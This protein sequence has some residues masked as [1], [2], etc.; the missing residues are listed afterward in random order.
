[1]FPTARSLLSQR[2]VPTRNGERDGNRPVV[3]VRSPPPNPREGLH[4]RHPGPRSSPGPADKS[5]PA[6]YRL[7]VHDPCVYTFPVRRGEPT[8]QTLVQTYRFQHRNVG[9]IV[10]SGTTADHLPEHARNNRLH[11]STY[12]TYYIGGRVFPNNIS[13]IDNATALPN[14]GGTALPIC[15][16]MDVRVPLHTISMGNPCIAAAS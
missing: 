2:R 16:Y 11:N 9:N 8:L 12:P 13:T 4:L 1:M 15:L 7:Q 6:A 10:G 5:L 3:P 14:G